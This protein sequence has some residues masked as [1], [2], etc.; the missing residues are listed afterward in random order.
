MVFTFIRPKSVSRA[1]RARP[2]TYPDLSK[3]CRATE[4]AI[5]SSGLWRDDSLVVEYTRLAKVFC[6]EDLEAL[7]RPGCLIHI[8]KA[9]TAVVLAGWKPTLEI[10]A[11]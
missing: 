4:D 6:N 10:E 7:P 3:L 1:K 9:P 8:E 2:C 5:T 11:A